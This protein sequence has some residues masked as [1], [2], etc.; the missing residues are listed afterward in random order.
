M[1]VNTG[2]SST[3]ATEAN[4]LITNLL[5][6]PEISPVVTD[7]F[8]QYSLN[9][10]I[11]N[12]KKYAKEVE[13]GSNNVSWFLKGRRSRPSI[14]D[15][16]YT[17]SATAG[18]G[19][20]AFVVDFAPGELHLYPKAVVRF[21]G[22]VNAWVESISGLQ[23]T[24]RL[25]D[26]SST[27][28]TVDLSA[29]GGMTVGIIGNM[30]EEG[31]ARGYGN[32]TFPDKYTNY[33]GIYRQ[34]MEI[35][36]DALTDKLWIEYNGQALWYHR[37]W[38]EWMEEIE[39]ERELARIYMH[40]TM[41]NAGVAFQYEPVSGKPLIHGDGLLKQI[42]LNNVDTYSGASLTESQIT[43]FLAALSLNTGQGQEY[44]VLGG[45]AGILAFETAMKAYAPAFG[46]RFAMSG[47]GDVTLGAN[48]RSFVGFNT[49][50]TIAHNPCFDDVNIHG[51]DMVTN[52]FGVYPKESYRLLFLNVGKQGVSNFNL[53]MAVKSAGGINRGRVIKYVNG[54]IDPMNPS[55]M[56]AASG[57]DKFKIE[58]LS[59]TALVLRNPWSCGMLVHA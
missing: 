25:Q 5:K 33:M 28:A 24:F 47:G 37:Q 50:L 18:A 14:I 4:S 54:M 8:P 59:H 1:I 16:A 10:F 27:P 31:S 12:T 15:P 32:Q 6:Y 53:E 40:A 39:Y 51:N 30:N 46:A 20:T 26:N 44:L 48:Y 42:G 7:L 29:P 52:A 41:N 13:Y 35:T 17:G 56:Y 36:G 45:T 49:K 9:Y 58:Y 34:E 3:S 22:E 23:V 38:A 57:D 19:N 2:N 55:S 11:E 21:P 43:S